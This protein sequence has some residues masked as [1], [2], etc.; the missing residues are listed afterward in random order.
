M[1][2]EVIYVVRHGVSFDFLSCPNVQ[3]LAP[4]RV[5]RRGHEVVWYRGFVNAIAPMEV[6][7]RNKETSKTIQ[8]YVLDW[9]TVTTPA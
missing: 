3:W 4:P 6:L 7:R 1:G 5:A 8:R 2:L 9:V